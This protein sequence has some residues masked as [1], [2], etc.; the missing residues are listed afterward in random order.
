MKK[1]GICGEVL[2]RGETSHL[3]RVANNQVSLNVSEQ[4]AKFFVALQHNKRLISGSIATSPVNSHQIKKLVDTL[5]ESISFVPEIH[6]LTPLLPICQQKPC[7]DR[8]DPEIENIDKKIM[9]RLYERVIQC[10]ASQ[11]IKTSGSFSAGMYEYGIINTLVDMPLYYKGTDYTI[12]TIL[13]LPEGKK[14]LRADSCGDTLS[15]YNPDTFLEE[16]DRLLHL[17]KSTECIEIEPGRYDVVFGSPA[18]ADL[19][20]FLSWLGFDGETYEYEMGM[21]QK[22]MHK[23]GD[24]ILGENF[25]L[26]DDPNDP[27]IVYGHPFG[28]N[29]VERKREKLFEKGILRYLYYSDKL[30][31]DRFGKKV[32][33]D[34]SAANLKVMA[35]DGPGS[36]DEMVESC[37]TQTLYIPYLHYMNSPNKAAGEITAT[38]RFGTFLIEKGRVSKHFV[39]FRLHDTLFTLFSNIEWLSTT[40]SIVNL[41]DTYDLRLASSLTSPLFMKAKGVSFSK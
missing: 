37:D 39:N 35:G 24:K 40:L 21:L 12:Q 11:G 32:N 1:R 10:Y 6:F 8:Y 38:T 30:S 16:F 19:I 20:S 29:G 4:G 25:T 31:S 17:I 2:Y 26:I 33:N 18:I 22:S 5:Y 13:Q 15:H 36:F 34:I 9:R 27:E 3:L 14:E 7:I 41:S 23:I 28:I